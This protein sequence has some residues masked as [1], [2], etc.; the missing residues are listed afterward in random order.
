VHQLP[1]HP[2]ISSSAPWQSVHAVMDF[3]LAVSDF[4]DSVASGVEDLVKLH[5]VQ[6][7]RFFLCTAAYAVKL[8]MRV[9][10]ELEGSALQLELLEDILDSEAVDSNAEPAGTTGQASSTAA[11]DP[12]TPEVLYG[13]FVRISLCAEA[14]YFVWHSAAAAAAVV[15]FG[16]LELSAAVRG[17][18]SLSDS[19]S[20]DDSEDT[21]CDRERGCQEVVAAVTGAGLNCELLFSHVILDE[22][23]AMLEP[24]MVGTIIHGC[25]FLLCVGDDKQVWRSG[26]VRS[27]LSRS[28]GH[29]CGRLEATDTKKNS[30]KVL[31]EA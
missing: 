2:D 6:S 22:A 31:F 13:K 14:A 17:G 27:R 25:R 18:D 11:A 30:S 28:S 23:G 15:V 8:P 26:S 19:V 21:S 7:A 12:V 10:R 4:V 16:L 5:I 3:L 24:D 1:L 20:A 29:A 9:S